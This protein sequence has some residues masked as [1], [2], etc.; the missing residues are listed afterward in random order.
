M[1]NKKEFA[2][3]AIKCY[4]KNPGTCSYIY[5]VGPVYFKD[6][7]TNCVIGQFLTRSAEFDRNSP[8]EALIHKHG[9]Q[10][11]ESNYRNILEPHEWQSLQHIHDLIAKNHF[12]KKLPKKEFTAKLNE[13]LNSLNLFTRKELIA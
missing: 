1:Y 2:L 8:I 10:I 9:E 13:Y 3:D 6:E 11:F 4:F 7:Y 5:G 12:D